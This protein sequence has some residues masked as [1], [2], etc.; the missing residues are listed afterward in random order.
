LTGRAARTKKNTLR[1]IRE[2]SPPSITSVLAL[3]PSASDS[4]LS[5]AVSLQSG[6]A[7]RA[8]GVTKNK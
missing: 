2:K 7:N 1:P 5:R 8:E 3:K 6:Q 4:E